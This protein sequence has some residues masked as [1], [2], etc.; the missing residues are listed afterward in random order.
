[1]NKY[2][3][4]ALL[5]CCVLWLLTGTVWG[6][7]GTQLEAAGLSGIQ[8][9]NSVQVCGAGSVNNTHWVPM[10]AGCWLECCLVGGWSPSC[11]GVCGDSNSL[12]FWGPGVRVVGVLSLGPWSP[13]FEVP[14][15]S[16]SQ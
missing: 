14:G 10:C 5:V 11:S 8:T 1:M 12:C 15:C 16:I 3:A 13:P 4:Q 2:S 9:L 7:A 6:G